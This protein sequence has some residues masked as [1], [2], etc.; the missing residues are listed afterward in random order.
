MRILW[1]LR[2]SLR[3][4]GLWR[5][6]DSMVEARVSERCTYCLHPCPQHWWC[7]VIRNVASILV[8]ARHRDSEH[9][10]QTVSPHI[11]TVVT[12]LEIPY[13]TNPVCEVITLFSGKDLFESRLSY[14]ITWVSSVFP[15]RCKDMGL[16][17]ARD[18]ALLLL[19]ANTSWPSSY[20]II[21][22]YRT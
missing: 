10:R 17:W 18:D 7:T 20:V 16:K 21:R 14:Q 11:A 13:N 12:S 3:S 22:T 6:M 1:D 19:H 8:S 2:F 5:G 15:S 9:H 4:F